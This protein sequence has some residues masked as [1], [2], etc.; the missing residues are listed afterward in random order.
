MYLATI[1]TPPTIRRAVI[2]GSVAMIAAGLG[3]AVLG[4]NHTAPDSAILPLLTG[5]VIVSELMSAYILLGQA[6]RS[7]SLWFLLL[8]VAYLVPGFLAI[9]Y[10]LAFPAVFGPHGLLGAGSQTSVYLWLLWHVSY[11]ALLLGGILSAPRHA[12]GEPRN[13]HVKRLTVPIVAACFLAVAAATVAIV[14][15]DRRLIVLVDHQRFTVFATRVVLPALFALDS[16]AFLA[17]WAR[18]RL[19]S[20]LATW[21]FV[22]LV[23]SMLDSVL[24]L[25]CDRYSLGWYAG[26][27]FMMVASSV[28]LIVF[29][30]EIGRLQTWLV[31]TNDKLER[32]RES[33]RRGA[34]E[35][36]SYLANHDELTRLYNRTRIEERLRAL[37][38]KRRGH[39]S[40]FGVLFVDLD[41]LKHIN[42]VFGRSSGDAVIVEAAGRI[43]DV[44]SARGMVGRFGSNEFVVVADASSAQEAETLASALHRSLGEPYAIFNR[45]IDATASIGIAMF[46]DD[47]SSADDLLDGAGAAAHRAKRDGGNQIR[48][49]SREFAEEARERRL[50]FGDLVLALERDEF[51]LHHQ[52]IVDLR[53]GR[54]VMVEALVR[55]RSPIRG[56]VPPGDFIPL[57]EQSDLMAPL[58]QWVIEEAARH[59]R[60]LRGDGIHAKMAINISACQLQ[61]AH[62][63][64]LLCKAVE[65]AALSPHDFELE[66]T[67]SAAMTD[68]ALARDTLARC[69]A[70]GFGIALDDFGTHYSSLTY[71]KRLPVDTVKI[72]RSFVSGLPA[73]DDDAA[74]VAGVIGLAKNLRRLVVAE[75]V[76]TQEQLAWLRRAGCDYA[77]G[78]FV[79]RPMPL[80]DLRAWRPP[81]IRS[82]VSVAG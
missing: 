56:I 50:L 17:L 12:D 18:T 22:A 7:E 39:E 44:I 72:D 5:A 66:V 28:M 77:Q 46:P 1:S 23:A 27:A 59:V 25:I 3:A 29:I 53:F 65:R 69:A 62:F 24:G 16:A 70:R 49:F 15:W 67:E 58:G 31:T 78:Y 75:G 68:A 6:R 26:K 35:R 13:K 19:R 33:E 41:R 57:A 11:P 2:A 64:D 4:K 38:A 21:L 36:L 71:L 42:E 63:F 52:P 9:P 10:I 45:S 37:V 14:A 51:F 30:A 82:V 34:Q 20:A 60:L 8:A 47:G 54:L 61:D 80:Q 48:M 73:N 43:Q 55:W 81:A 32:S 76:E 40:R 79:A 74:I